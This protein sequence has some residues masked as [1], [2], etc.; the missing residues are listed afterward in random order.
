MEKRLVDLFGVALRQRLPDPTWERVPD[1][2]I[3]LLIEIE[4]VETGA[5]ASRADTTKD[6]KLQPL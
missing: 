4:E 5:A 2:M 1:D 6:W 3:R